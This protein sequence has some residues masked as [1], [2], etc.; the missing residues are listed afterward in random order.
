MCVYQRYA[1]T[2]LPLGEASK[3][4]LLRVIPTMTCEN[5][6]ERLYVS[7]ISCQVGLLDIHLISWNASGYF[8]L[9]R[10]TV[11]HLLTLFLTILSDMFSDIVSDISSNILLTYLLAFFLTF[12]VANLLTVFLTFLLGYLLAVFLTFFLAS[13]LT[14][15]LRLRTATRRVRTRGWG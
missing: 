15:F 9:H 11:G 1:I 4:T 12:F 6:H 10:L 7:L 13:L 5:S 3:N 8:Q 2:C 14:F